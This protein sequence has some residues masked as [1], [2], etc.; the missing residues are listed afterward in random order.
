MDAEDVFELLNSRD[1]ELTINDLTELKKQTS[2]EETDE[3]F[4]PMGK[5]KQLQN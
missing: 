3:E 2:V 5:I 1:P 4:E